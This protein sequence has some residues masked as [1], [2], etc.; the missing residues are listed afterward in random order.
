MD[1]NKIF[2]SWQNMMK[3]NAK[4]VSTK[5]LDAFIDHCLTYSP[6]KML[7][8]TAAKLMKK[9]MILMPNTILAT[10]TSMI[11]QLE[12]IFLKPHEEMESYM[13]VLKHGI[14]E[15][16]NDK[17]KGIVDKKWIIRQLLIPCQKEI[18]NFL[19]LQA[20]IQL[21]EDSIG[22]ELWI[23]YSLNIA[24]DIVLELAKDKTAISIM[25]GELIYLIVR[26]Y[27]KAKKLLAIS[28]NYIEKSLAVL[29]SLF[30]SLQTDK[31]E[32]RKLIIIQCLRIMRE[33]GGDEETLSFL[34][35]EMY[36]IVN[37]PKPEQHY[38]V[39]LLKAISQDMYIRG[40]M[41]KDPY[42]ASSLGTTM[43]DIRSKICKDIEMRDAEQIM[44][45]LVGKKIIDLELPIKLVY[46]KVWWPY[47]FRLRNPDIEEIPP[48]D[49]A[50]LSELEPMQVI[51]RLAGVDGEAT[52]PRIES[53]SDDKSG[54]DPEKIFAVT[55]VFANQEIVEQG[56]KS[57]PGLGMML[58]HL[59]KIT[60]L[61]K[62]RFLTEKI[63]KLLSVATK[64]KICREKVIEL[65]GTNILAGKL[66][67]FLP[68]YETQK[69]SIIDMLIFIVEDIITEAN[70][71]VA[72]L[73]MQGNVVDISHIKQIL[74][75]LTQTCEKMIISKE[76]IASKP[77]FFKDF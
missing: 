25:D 66:I 43:K 12:I 38:Q 76:N 34:Y 75:R 4:D 23:G 2:Q 72:L 7:R 67:E 6:C 13:N 28:N 19:A 39:L 47:I 29:E 50:K 31:I 36:D 52:E 77:L 55:S 15:L 68:F 11:G 58:E 45:L 49:G 59:G 8:N 57:I 33:I 69:G 21:R 54:E 46:E 32:E 44:E 14:T 74:E 5:I 26:S 37:P 65:K 24:L 61:Q 73:S 60:S 1:L 17:Y 56:Q 71:S 18:D 30:D 53:L 48:I 9:L 20:H 62:Q 40:S 10:V 27:V 51:F 35:E 22:E 70:K 42:N 63:I 3:V 41:S 16:C 64:T